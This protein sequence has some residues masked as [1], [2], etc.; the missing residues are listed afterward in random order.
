MWRAAPL[1]SG[2]AGLG[3]V[4]AELAQQR[5]G[6]PDTDDPAVSLQF[7]AANPGAHAVAG[8]WL[9]VASLALIATVLATSRRLDVE[10]SLGAEYLRVV[11]ILAGA[12]LVGMAFTRF[13][14]GPVRY[15]QGLDQAWGEAAYL[16]TQFV[17]TQLLAVGG[18]LL[19]AIW[20]AGAAWLGAAR[21]VLP[22]P[23][24]A[25]ALLPAFRLVGIAGPLGFTFDGGWLLTML[26]IPAA[27]AWLAAFGA[28]Q[29]VRPS[30]RSQV[31][32]ATPVPL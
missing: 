30:S 22:R 17:G 18:L 4:W 11:G 32:A 26:A 7:L 16:V 13:A 20:I 12:M 27:F 10:G 2:L 19:L 21:D 5:A 9:L 29:L 14:A 3:W 15:V 31:A 23:L 24:A 8:L 6:F 28:W 25:L 1:L